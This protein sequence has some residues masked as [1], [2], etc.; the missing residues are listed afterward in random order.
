MT[1]RKEMIAYAERLGLG[2]S[3]YSPGDGV[4]RYRFARPSDQWDN[5]SKP[6]RLRREE[7]AREYFGC[8]P[9]YT[10]LGLKECLTYLRGY[11]NGMGAPKIA[12]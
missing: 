10:A 2:V 6:D 3:T 9:L 11:E 7:L 1:T 12:T 8:R 5:S 4:T